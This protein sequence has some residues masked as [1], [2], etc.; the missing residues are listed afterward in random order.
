MPITE[1]VYSVLFE[2]KDVLT[3]LSELMSRQP[4]PEREA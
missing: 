4:K 2:N 3:A 1:S